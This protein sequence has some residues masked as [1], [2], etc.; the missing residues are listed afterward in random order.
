VSFGG[1]PVTRPEDVH[2]L[3]AEGAIGKSLELK[4][5]RGGSVQQTSIVV[6]ERQHGGE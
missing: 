2:S 6:S 3:L 4:L 1:H 5:V